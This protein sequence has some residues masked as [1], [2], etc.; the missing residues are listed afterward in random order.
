MPLGNNQKHLKL[1]KN[2]CEELGDCLRSSN[3]K[4]QISNPNPMIL[5]QSNPMVTSQNIVEKSLAKLA[6]RR[7]RIVDCSTLSIDAKS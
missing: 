6:Q 5:A 1:R 3:R 2:A 4:L 7:C